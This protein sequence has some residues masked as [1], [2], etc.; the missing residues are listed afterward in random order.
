[1]LFLANVFRRGV[2]L[3]EQNMSTERF[4]SEPLTKPDGTKTSLVRTAFEARALA[5][6]SGYR[7]GLPLCFGEAKVVLRS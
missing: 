4:V 1:M 3:Q 2:K 6:P 5:Y 7:P